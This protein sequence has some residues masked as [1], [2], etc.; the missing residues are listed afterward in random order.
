MF[1]KLII[2]AILGVL[3]YA[4]FI[5]IKTRII[6]APP[7]ASLRLKSR[8]STWG[9]TMVGSDA[10]SNSVGGIRTFARAALPTC[11][12]FDPRSKPFLRV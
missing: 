7:P 1:G 5:R 4:L 8:S 10:D 3:L 9:P 6:G 11:I 12:S 2:F